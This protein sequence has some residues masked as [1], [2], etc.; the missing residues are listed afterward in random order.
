[1]ITTKDVK[2]EYRNAVDVWGK[3][4]TTD[5]KKLDIMF[6]LITVIIKIVLSNRG[7]STRIMKKLGVELVAPRRRDEDGSRMD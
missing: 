6:K 3:E 2:E 1:M 7:N 4:E 5:S